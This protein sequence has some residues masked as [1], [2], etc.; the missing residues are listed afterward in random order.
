[1][2]LGLGQ[3]VSGWRWFFGYEEV[4]VLG[5]KNKKN[6]RIEKKIPFQLFSP[7]ICQQKV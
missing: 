3:S 5:G 4:L 6:Q 7:I 2:G 1:M